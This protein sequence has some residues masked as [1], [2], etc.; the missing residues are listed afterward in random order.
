[1]TTYL[2]T[3]GGGNLACR[4]THRLAGPGRRIVLF[5]RTP[6]PSA[7]VAAGCRFV[8]GDITSEA[9]LAKLFDERIDVILHFAS[10]LSGSSEVD[11]AT[12][13]R[14]NVD[15]AFA[16]FEL[17]LRH[18][19]PRFFFPSS[20]AS[21]GR[22]LP[23]LIDDD[24]PQWPMGIY[25]VTKVAVERLGVYYHERH[26]LDFRGLRV[27]VVV[28]PH[29]APGAASS[30][31]SRAFV[32]A[33]TQGAF[34]FRVRP[35]SRPSLVYVKD[36]VEAFVQLVEAPA[37][38]L[39]RRVYNMQA[40]S[41]TALEIAEAIRV[42]LPQAELRFDPDPAI[43]DLIDS[44]PIAFNDASARHDWNWSPRFGLDALAD[45]ILSEIRGDT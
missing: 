15:A 18:S 11:R 22:P 45:D 32:E 7:P 17:A 1:M 10:L 3:G 40:L 34:T 12:T 41:P 13:W 44:W 6:A 20:V 9:D 31:A 25:G 2:I 24:Q 27:P 14:I 35:E 30:Y 5:D 23:A 26:G 36:V 16:M 19:V 8:Q 42:R 29:A 28:S 38:R 37:S 21:F 4:L 43:A 39:T 33:Q